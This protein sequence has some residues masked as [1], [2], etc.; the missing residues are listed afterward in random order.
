MRA[1][2]PAAMQASNDVGRMVCSTREPAAVEQHRRGAASQ[3]GTPRRS[4]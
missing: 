3:R 1:A 2:S 4:S